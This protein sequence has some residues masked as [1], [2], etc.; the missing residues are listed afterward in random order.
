MNKKLKSIAVNKL[1]EIKGKAFVHEYKNNFAI[2]Y[3]DNDNHYIITFS[4]SKDTASRKNNGISNYE[5]PI[6]Q[7]LILRI[8]KNSEIC[9]IIENTL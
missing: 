9:N 2:S 8:N 3:Q 4:L 7:N 6:E 5:T 1:I